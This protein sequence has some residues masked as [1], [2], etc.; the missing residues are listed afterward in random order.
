MDTSPEAELFDEGNLIK[1]SPVEAILSHHVP[2]TDIGTIQLFQALHRPHRGIAVAT[3]RK[4]H[5]F[6][7]Y[8]SAFQH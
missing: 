2:T 7:Q 6:S 4:H 3:K 5:I 8:V 1:R